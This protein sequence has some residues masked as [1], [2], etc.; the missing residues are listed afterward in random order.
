MKGGRQLAFSSQ[1]QP[2]PHQKKPP[3]AAVSRAKKLSPLLRRDRFLVESKLGHWV[4]D[5]HKY[6]HFRVYLPVRTM[7]QIY[8]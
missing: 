3:A 5:L 4:P 6:V 2:P 8:S 1:Q 7:P